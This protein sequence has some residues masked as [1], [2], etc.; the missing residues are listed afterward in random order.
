MDKTHLAAFWL[1]CLCLLAACQ[2]PS[3]SPGGSADVRA[4]PASSAA[5]S[6]LE[7]PNVNLEGIER[8][9]GHAVG[10]GGEPGRFYLKLVELTKSLKPAELE[11]L[12]YSPSPVGQSARRAA[13]ANTTIRRALGLGGLAR[14]R[15]GSARRMLERSLH[16]RSAIEYFP[17]GCVGWSTTL[18]AF[19]WE[20]LRDPDHLWPEPKPKGLLEASELDAINLELLAADDTYAFHWNVERSLEEA[21]KSGRLRYELGELQRH[22]PGLPAWRIVLALGRMPGSD[23]AR[24]A[25]LA[26]LPAQTA[27]DPQARLAAA[28][29]LTRRADDAAISALEQQAAALDALGSEHWGSRLLDEARRHRAFRRKM[30][31]LERVKTWMENERLADSAVAAFDVDDAFAV[32]ALLGQ[33]SSSFGTRSEAVH[34]ARDAALLRIAPRLRDLPS[35]STWRDV[36]YQ[37]EQALLRPSELPSSLSALTRTKLREAL[38]LAPARP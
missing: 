16:D 6:R 38:K 15:A 10:E 34:A 36:P 8:I 3:A 13:A 31:P 17:G 26:S 1:S 35:F 9:E 22:T 4:A 18:G 23:R 33:G 11:A 5:A 27:L 14:L 2:H 7:P 32:D 12:V 30:A 24:A 25:L 20:L 19:A 29:A 28:S 21:F 37:L